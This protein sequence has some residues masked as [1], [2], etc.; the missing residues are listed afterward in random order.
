MT[1]TVSVGT[2]PISASDWSSGSTRASGYWWW[3]LLATLVYKRHLH[4]VMVAR[5]LTASRQIVFG[6]FLVADEV[7]RGHLAFR[8][9][10]NTATFFHFVRLGFRQQAGLMLGKDTNTMLPKHFVL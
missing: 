6:H 8:P 7:I 9:H 4:A 10:I 1:L 3:L 2:N 5:A